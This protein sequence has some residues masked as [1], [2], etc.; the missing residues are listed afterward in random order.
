MCPCA[1]LIMRADNHGEGDCGV[2]AL[3]DV[4]HAPPKACV[5]FS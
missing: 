4:Q 2:A 5:H 3:L 1:I